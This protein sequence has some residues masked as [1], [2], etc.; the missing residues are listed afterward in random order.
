MHTVMVTVTVGLSVK[1][2]IS[3]PL[4]LLHIVPKGDPSFTICKGVELT[5]HP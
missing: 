3:G 4:V 5:C 1:W 2:L